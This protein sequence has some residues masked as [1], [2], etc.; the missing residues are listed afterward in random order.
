MGQVGSAN[1]SCYSSINH[2]SA[3]QR[4]CEPRGDGAEI[5]WR[6]IEQKEP[7]GQ[8][9]WY[10]W[11][12]TTNQTSFTEPA[13]WLP[14]SPDSCGESSDEVCPTSSSEDED[15]P[16]SDDDEGEVNFN[17]LDIIGLGEDMKLCGPDDDDDDDDEEELTS[18]TGASTKEGDELS[19]PTAIIEPCVNSDLIA[20]ELDISN[21]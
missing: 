6:M 2:I 8:S 16:P 10:W 5:E 17:N 4:F 19:A 3:P 14:Y 9:Y 13:Q 11:N 12:R 15:G 7:N 21:F 1:S 20:T 18:I